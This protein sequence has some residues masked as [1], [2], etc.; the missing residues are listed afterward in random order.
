MKRYNKIIFVCDS[1]TARAPMAEAIMKEYI[2]KYPVEIESRGLVVLFPE[3]LNQKT[4]AVL[5]SNGISTEHQMSKQLMEEDLQPEHLIIAMESAQKQKILEEYKDSLKA[6]VEV[7]TD[8]TGDELEILNP[9]GGTLQSYGLC[10]ET[11]NKTIKKL[12][13]LINEGE[14]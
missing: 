2:I 3:P 14:G 13:N 1:G 4:E 11:L 5:I 8:L 12:V 10:Y 7:L 6:E 9:Y